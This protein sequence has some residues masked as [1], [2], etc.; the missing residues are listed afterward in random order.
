M[1]P[2]GI[3]SFVYIE[4]VLGVK[5]M[6]IVQYM[7]NCWVSGRRC[8]RLWRLWTLG[9]SRYCNGSYGLRRGR[10]LLCTPED[11]HEGHGSRI[12]SLVYATLLY[13]DRFQRSDYCGRLQCS[14][15]SDWLQFSECFVNWDIRRRSISVC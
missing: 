1:N 10:I 7:R 15:Y 4:H 8:L 2:K 5:R 12:L 3:K 14:E 9:L 11:H 6:A 13:C